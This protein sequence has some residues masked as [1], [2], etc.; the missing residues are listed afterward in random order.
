VVDD[1]ERPVN[2]QG[3]SRESIVIEDDV[4]LGVGVTVVAGVT[5]GHDSVVATRSLVTRDVP[6]F[7]VVAGV[8]A[9]VVR[10]RT[11]TGDASGATAG[12]SGVRAAAAP[13][14]AQ[15]ARAT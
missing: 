15:K 2:A 5:I 1:S 3:V 7:A 14:G 9:R 4:W 8:P 10:S 6:P 12:G 13:E 11:A